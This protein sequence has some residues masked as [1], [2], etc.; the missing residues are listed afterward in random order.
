[1]FIIS[2]SEAGMLRQD[3]KLTGKYAFPVSCQIIYNFY[4]FFC[5]ELNASLFY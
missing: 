2:F 4:A 5:Y 1:M 3:N